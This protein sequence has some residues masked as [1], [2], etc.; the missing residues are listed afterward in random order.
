MS[1]Q[2]FDFISSNLPGHINYNNFTERSDQKTKQ[3]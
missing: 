3:N 1:Y 2:F